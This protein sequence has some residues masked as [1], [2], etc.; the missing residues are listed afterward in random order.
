MYSG[1]RFRVRH[2]NY[3]NENTRSVF[4]RISSQPDV[5]AEKMKNNPSLSF[6]R[7]QEFSN[8]TPEKYCEALVRA[9]KDFLERN[10]TMRPYVYYY[11]GYGGCH[12]KID[13]SDPREP[14]ENYQNDYDQKILE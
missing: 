4:N 8:Y 2:E 3:L 6:A 14:S 12:I 9:T 5:L 11:Q 13:I 7:G 10:P 1:D